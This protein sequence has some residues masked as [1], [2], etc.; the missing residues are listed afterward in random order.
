MVSFSPVSLLSDPLSITASVP[1]P[2]LSSTTMP[3]IT[4]LVSAK[5][6]AD[7]STSNTS[8]MPTTST[9]VSTTASPLLASTSSAV[10]SK[11]TLVHALSTSTTSTMPSTSTLVVTTT[12]SH[13]SVLS[14]SQTFS[15]PLNSSLAPTHSLV[16]EISTIAPGP[17]V[18]K[19]KLIRTFWEGK[20]ETNLTK[21]NELATLNTERFSRFLKT[22]LISDGKGS[23]I[24]AIIEQNETLVQKM[25]EFTPISDLVDDE[26]NCL[27]AAILARNKT[28]VSILLN[29]GIDPL[30][31]ANDEDDKPKKTLLKIAMETDDDSLIVLIANHLIKKNEKRTI[32]IKKAQTLHKPT[33]NNRMSSVFKD[34]FQVTQ[35]D[36]PVKKDAAIKVICSPSKDGMKKLEV[37]VEAMKLLK[38]KG[39]L[40]NVVNVL[41]YQQLEH[42]LTIAMDLCVGTVSDHLAKK[43][44]E[45]NLPD[46][47]RICYQLINGVVQ[48][49]GDTSKPSSIAHLDLKPSNVFL[50]DPH[51]KDELEIL[52]GDFGCAEILT[53]DRIF[54]VEGIGT[55]CY[56]SPERLKDLEATILELPDGDLI[57]AHV[58]ST[59]VDIWSCG[60]M[61]Y[62][63]LSRDHTLIFKYI[64]SDGDH[65]ILFSIKTFTRAEAE[66]KTNLKK[67]GL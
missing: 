30:S 27:E 47:P 14:T 18:N 56:M 23:L 32:H 28:L 35:F 51:L 26:K 11:S 61:L 17:V 63:L 3:S 16:S 19:L 59:K 6:L 25:L 36:E 52:I 4:T 42:R 67:L 39:K 41:D 48:I 38:E 62:V 65:E 57:E 22:D 24:F 12:P 58:R 60:M 49:H 5:T 20:A 37:E 40:T 34:K 2:D 29:H 55:P 66:F 31:I 9:L 54:R 53:E 15:T 7:L 10:P 8:T 21:P 33:S 43:S 45:K 46:N 44:F 1:V 13:V 50:H 64:E